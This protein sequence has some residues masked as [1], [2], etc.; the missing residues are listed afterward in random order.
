[1]AATEG[2]RGYTRGTDQEPEQKYQALERFTRDL[3]G[4]GPQGQDR[5]K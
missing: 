2:V 4:S 3:P 1:M 5:T